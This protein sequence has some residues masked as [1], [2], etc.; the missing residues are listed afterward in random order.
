MFSFAGPP[1]FLYRNPHASRSPLVSE[2]KWRFAL[3]EPSASFDLG[4]DFLLPPPNFSVAEKLT[5]HKQ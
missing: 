3:I 4:R 2:R 1:T 5:E